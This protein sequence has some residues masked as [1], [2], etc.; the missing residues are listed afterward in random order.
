MD[1]VD[2]SQAIAGGQYSVKGAGRAAALDVSQDN[3]SSFESDAPFDFASQDISDAAQPCMTEFVLLHVLH[4]RS[5]V[6]RIHIGRKFGSLGDDD[7][8]EVASASMAQANGL[9]DFLDIERTLRNEN[10][11]G[12]TGNAAVDGD[13]AC[14]TTHHFHDHDTV[15]SFGSRVHAVDGLGDDIDRGIESE[16]V[17]SAGQIIVDGFG[18][19][20]YFH[21]FLM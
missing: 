14:I 15:V 11:I 10:Y 17:V 9:C 4:N 7:N 1:H 2:R 21:A 13:P 3:G 8:A 18:N 6:L 12:A 16:S 5:T 19:A 20:Y